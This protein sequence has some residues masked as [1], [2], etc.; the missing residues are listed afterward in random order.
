MTEDRRGGELERIVALCRAS[1]RLG[2][3]VGLSDARPAVVVRPRTGP[4]WWI[5][6]DDEGEFFEWPAAGFRHPVADPAGAAALIHHRVAYPV[7]HHPP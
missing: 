2:L 4:P 6:V 3:N 7:E 1:A 5:T